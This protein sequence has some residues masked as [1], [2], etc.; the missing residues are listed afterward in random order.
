MPAGAIIGGGASILGGVLGGKGAKKAAKAEVALGRDALALQERMFQQGRADLAPWRDAGGQAIGQGLA[1]LQQGYVH[2]TSP[3]YQF[4]FGEGVRAVDSS[5]ASKGMLM[6]G[7]TLKDLTRFGQGVAADDFNDQFNSLSD[8]KIIE[9]ERM[10]RNII[11]A[12]T[13][14][15]FGYERDIIKVYGANSRVLLFPKR[16]V[17]VNSVSVNG[18]PFGMYPYTYN[19]IKSGY[20]IEQ[21]LDYMPGP[22]TVVAPI[23]DPSV[24]PWSVFRENVSY[25]VDGF[26]GWVSVPSDIKQAALLLAELFSCKEATWRD[27]Y[28]RAMTAADWRVD[29]HDRAFTGTG[30]RAVDM[31]LL[32]YRVNNMAII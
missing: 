30:S 18:A 1:M 21:G 2:T 6:S 27:R 5:A 14:Q 11:G 19:A 3:G 24:G 8:P 13:G 12:Y 23:N 20:G 32:E 4:R 17:E 29:F 22:F 15:E 9:L 25:Y 28:I 26:F 10:C 31:I 16:I 7:G